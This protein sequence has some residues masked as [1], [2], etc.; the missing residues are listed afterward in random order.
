MNFKEWVKQAYGVNHDDHV[1]DVLVRLHDANAELV[2][3][4]LGIYR[5]GMDT[6]SGRVDGT[7]DR[8]WQREAVK[9]MSYR[10]E[11]AIR[12]QTSNPAEFH[13]GIESAGV[14]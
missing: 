5:Y 6:L 14:E 2:E 10:A 11:D 13:L 3:A 7:D 8:A 12:S 4:L 9:E 1:A